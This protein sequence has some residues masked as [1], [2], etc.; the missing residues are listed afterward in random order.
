[1]AKSG[2]L[3]DESITA[4]ASPITSDV[5][6]GVFNAISGQGTV[7]LET[8]I[9]SL[10]HLPPGMIRAAVSKLKEL[11]V[12]H[13]SLAKPLSLRSEAPLVAVNNAVDSLMKD[14]SQSQEALAGVAQSLTA[15]RVAKGPVNSELIEYLQGNDT[16]A[17][18]LHDLAAMATFSVDSLLPS[19]PNEE[20]LESAYR[21]DSA[22]SKRGV[23][24]RAIYPEAARSNNDIMR[25]LD[26]LSG[27]STEVRTCQTTPLRMVIFD[28][29][30]AFI[31]VELDE[32]ESMSVV[33]NDPV[34]LIIATSFFDSLWTHSRDI[35]LREEKNELTNREMSV[36]RSMAI[37]STDAA[38]AR[39]LGIAQRTV[40]RAIESL[41]KRTGAKTRFMLG[42][43]AQR[44]GWLDDDV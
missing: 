5:F 44:I 11:G 23:R 28:R 30:V 26:E 43:E 32:N 14:L 12:I 29:K 39:E 15:A 16:I 22:L 6:F 8:L 40:H 41:Q 25:Y 13:S 18:R 10:Q 4:D 42:A 37:Y 2:H 34:T 3:P 21:G 19:I 20:F 9:D 35:C 36:L 31:R 1:M 38:I 33:V 17:R 27:C 24:L 7:A